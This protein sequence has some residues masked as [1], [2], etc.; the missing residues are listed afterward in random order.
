MVTS[1][2]C[3]QNDEELIKELN[4]PVS[5]LVSVL[6]QNNFEFKLG[7]NNDGFKYTLNF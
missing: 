6:V 5:S 7:P 4:N 2:L 3:R 1:V